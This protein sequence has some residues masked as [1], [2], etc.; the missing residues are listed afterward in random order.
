VIETIEPDAGLKKEIASVFQ[1]EGHTNRLEFFLVRKI[2]RPDRV[3]HN[4]FA[5]DLDRPDLTGGPS[6]TLTKTGEKWTVLASGG[7][8]E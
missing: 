2:T 8:Q 6:L 4:V 5:K 7:W 1:S 3:E